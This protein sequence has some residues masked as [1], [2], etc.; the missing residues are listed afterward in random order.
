[1][2][3][4]GSISI[5]ARSQ[6]CILTED[7]EIIEQRIRTTPERFHGGAGRAPQSANSAEASTESEWVARHLEGLGHEVI[8]GDPTF[9]PM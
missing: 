6:L 5:S 7:G 8:I 1:M 9:A 2:D 3:N 4:I